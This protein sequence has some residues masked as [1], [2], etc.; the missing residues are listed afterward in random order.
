MATMHEVEVFVLVDHKG[1]YVAHHDPD[2]LAEFW[3]EEIGAELKA[4]DGFRV[5]KLAVKVPLPAMIEVRGEVQ[6]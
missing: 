5:V 1:N 2:K 4:V 6:V 3:E